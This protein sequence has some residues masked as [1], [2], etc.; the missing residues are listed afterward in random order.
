MIALIMKAIMKAKNFKKSNFLHFLFLFFHIKYAE[1]A[2]SMHS[3]NIV[4]DKTH[5]QEGFIYE[6]IFDSSTTCF[7]W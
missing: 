3:I 7:F 4:S 6:K 2:L 1:Y 5:N